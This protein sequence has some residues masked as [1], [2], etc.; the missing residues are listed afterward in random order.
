ML[1]VLSLMIATT[2]SLG[3]LFPKNIMTITSFIV[4]I[5]R[6]LF[7]YSDLLGH[8][9]VYRR[10]LFAVSIKTSYTNNSGK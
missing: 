5:K 8:K 6:C 2:L 1:Y 3:V 9:K 4:T 7:L 10:L